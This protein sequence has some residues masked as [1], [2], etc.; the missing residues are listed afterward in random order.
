MEVEIEG[1]K[2]KHNN[3]NNNNN[4]NQPHH[5]NPKRDYRKSQVG[6]CRTGGAS[7]FHTLHYSNKIHVYTGH[8]HQVEYQAL[9]QPAE[10]N[11]PTNANMTID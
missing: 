7:G 8:I 9:G 6:C 1:A 4:N 2:I 5:R 11:Q 3:N 10:A